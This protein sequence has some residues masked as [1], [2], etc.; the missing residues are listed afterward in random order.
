ML[1]DYYKLY[2]NDL[3]HVVPT[4]VY[5]GL[6]SILCTVVVGLLLYGGFK[7]RIHTLLTLVLIE[8][9]IVLLSITVFFRESHQPLYNH[10][11]T[12]FWCFEGIK[13]GNVILI[14]EKAMN[15]V[16]FVP[17]GFF[18]RC[19]FIRL[20][21]WHIILLGLGLSMIIEVSQLVLRCGTADI[22]DIILNTA[23]CMIGVSI[24][25]SFK[26][27]WRLVESQSKV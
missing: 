10:L 26:E 27:I 16:A 23:G 13:N 7:K 2:V 19:V 22:D 12:P 14:T 15:V 17:I 11:S 4:I 3:F 8:Y 1:I 24:Y 25:V 21:W 5:V 6:I 9:L 18:M 20:K